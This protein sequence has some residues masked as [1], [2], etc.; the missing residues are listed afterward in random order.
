MTIFS[1][2][3]LLSQFGTSLLFHVPLCFFLTCIQISQVAGRMICYSHLLKNSPQFVVI[4]IVKG[5]GIVSRAEIDV[6]LELSCFFDDP[7]FLSASLISPWKYSSPPYLWFC[8]LWF[9]LTKVDL[10]PKRLNE[11]S[12]RHKQFISFKLHTVLSSMMQCLPILLGP[13]DHVNHL[14]VQGI[15]S[16]SHLVIVLVFKHFT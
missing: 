16:I 11:S 8:F 6:F 13:A 14:F 9:Q 3:V 10:C 7:D 2:D 5:F 12:S 15:L 1:L 4:H